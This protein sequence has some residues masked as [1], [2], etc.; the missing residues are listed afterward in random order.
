MKANNTVPAGMAWKDFVAAKCVVA[1]TPAAATP[2]KVTKA[3]MAPPEPT[4]KADTTPLATTDKNGKPYT[5]GQMAAHQ[6]IRACGEQWRGLKA[7]GKTP[8]GMAWPQYWSA[9]NKQLK[10]KGQ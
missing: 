5:A 3:S 6:R 1:D 8:A 10:A 2:A 4:D 9:C 7:Q